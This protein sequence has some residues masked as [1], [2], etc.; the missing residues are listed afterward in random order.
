[1]KAF[2]KV[3]TLT[4]IVAGLT[5][6]VSLQA[7]E[8]QSV[9]DMSSYFEPGKSFVG[10]DLP[11]Q[12]DLQSSGYVG[13]LKALGGYVGDLAL[14]EPTDHST[15][16]P[17]TESYSSAPTYSAPVARRGSVGKAMTRSPE[18]WLSAELLLWFPEDRTSP[19]LVASANA[20]E[21]PLPGQPGYTELFGG[22]IDS[23][24]QPGFRADAGRYFA[25]GQ[26]GLG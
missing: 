22:S 1:M 16:L 5:A 11:Q 8:P 21:I 15:P 7:Q 12:A 17:I 23:G 6:S 24:L 20:G 18:S 9:G 3:L 2:S 4:S 14:I 10:D 25:D 13:D 26:L 19:L